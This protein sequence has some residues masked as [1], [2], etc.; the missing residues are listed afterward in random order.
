[1]TMKHRREIARGLVLMAALLAGTAAAD[2]RISAAVADFDNHD[3]SGEVAEREAEHAAR[4]REFAGLLRATLDKAGKVEALALECAAAPCSAG[5]TDSDVLLQAARET[6]AELLVYGGIH[7]VSTLIQWGQVQVVDV[8]E[9]RLLLDR[10]FS[11]RGDTDEAFRR[12]AEFVAGY[13]E[14]VA[15]GS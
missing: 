5:S 6:G 3:T 8:D 4:V 2:E 9:N 7:K 1:M 10:S 14:D 11:F 15:P 13:L 12:A